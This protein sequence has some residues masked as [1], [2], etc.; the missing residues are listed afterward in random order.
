MAGGGAGERQVN[1]G[2]IIGS[3]CDGLF[4]HPEALRGLLAW[5]GMSAPMPLHD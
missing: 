5:A 2:Q 1:D 4:D 3:Y